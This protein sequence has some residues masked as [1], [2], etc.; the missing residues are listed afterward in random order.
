MLPVKDTSTLTV[1][2]LPT[3]ITANGYDVY[4]Y[5]DGDNG[6]ATRAG[7]FAL[8]ATTQVLTDAA[9]AKFNGTFYQAVSGGNGNYL[10]FSNQTAASFTITATPGTASDGNA[11][12]PL[13]GVEIVAHPG[14]LTVKSVL[15]GRQ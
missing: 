6:G 13:N 14:L 7:S 12:A 5:S 15:R 10:I 2:N 11:R 8:G 9:G 4:V 1:S 3:S